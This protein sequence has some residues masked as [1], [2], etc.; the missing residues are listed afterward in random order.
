M[1][2]IVGACLAVLIAGCSSK[3]KG[4][5]EPIGPALA[6]ELYAGEVVYIEHCTSCHHVAGDGAKSLVQSPVVLGDKNALIEI[7][8]NGKNHK[9]ASE[10][11]TDE[12][13]ASVLTYIRNMFGNKAD[14]V[15]LSDIRKD[16]IK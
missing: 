6:K 1:R 14:M 2:I 12:D 16:S 11:L 8:L 10:L 5:D 4:S 13:L 15:S 9:A 7:T 3:N